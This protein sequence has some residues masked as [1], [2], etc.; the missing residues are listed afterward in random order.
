[1]DRTLQVATI[2]IIVERVGYDGRERKISIRFR[3]P[4]TALAAEGRI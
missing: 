4:A 2:R 1:M 3:P